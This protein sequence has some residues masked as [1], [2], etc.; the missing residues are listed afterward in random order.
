MGVEE[1]R[2]RFERVAF[3]Q[4]LGV[5][6]VEVSHERAVLRLPFQEDNA[7]QGSVL[8]GGATA[9]LIHMAGTLAAWTDIDLQAAPLVNTA[10]LAI[11]Y[12]DAAF[13]E[14]ITA[15]AMV[16]H[17]GRDI[18]FLDVTVRG[19]EHQLISKG[20]MVC[21]A[22]HYTVPMRLYSRPIPP[23]TAPTPNSPPVLKPNH[24]DFTHKL[25]IIT[26]SHSPGIVRLAMPWTASHGDE[27]GNIHSGALAALLD[28]AATHASWSL[29]QQEGSRGATVGMQ[30][31]YPD[32]CHTDVVAEA[33]VE[34]RSE[35]MF[36]NLV[37]VRGVSTGRLVAMGNVSYRLLEGR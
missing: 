28:T 17:R 13:Y 27:Q 3:A 37:Q 22:P 15:E 8:H 2:A 31:S 30:L 36:F 5:S 16:L 14:E 1:A 19:E 11:Q 25:Q 32:M 6:V 29:V 9:S 4:F 23:A 12:L 24:Q 35:E 10:N 21:R 18:F 20:L 34:Q 33:H 7:N 26:L